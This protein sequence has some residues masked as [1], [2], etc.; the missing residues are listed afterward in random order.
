MKK[1]PSY[2]TWVNDGWMMVFGWFAGKLNS[3]M[4]LLLLFA[5]LYCIKSAYCLLYYEA[6]ISFSCPSFLM[7]SL[8]QTEVFQMFFFFCFFVLFCFLF[9]GVSHPR[10]ETELKLYESMLDIAVSGSSCR[11]CDTGKSLVVE[12]K[13]WNELARFFFCR[14]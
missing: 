5:L 2:Q 10:I 7:S 14:I 6:V 9:F 11:H 3:N 8:L 4:M 13:I 1:N 12:R